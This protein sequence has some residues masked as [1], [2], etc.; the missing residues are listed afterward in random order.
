VDV[1]LLFSLREHPG[2][3]LGSRAKAAKRESQENLVFV[4]F[5]LL[6]LKSTGMV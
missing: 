4:W 6:F 2:A 5:F 1:W 3:L